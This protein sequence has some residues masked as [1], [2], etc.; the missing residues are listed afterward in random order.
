MPHVI[1]VDP[2]SRTAFVDLTG[3]VDGAEVIATCRELLTHPDWE[4][5]FSALWD[6]SELHELHLLPEHI[7]GFMAE[8]SGFRRRRGEGRTAV[9]AGGVNARLSALLFSIQA[10]ANSYRLFRVFG[11]ADEGEAWLA[12]GEGVHVGE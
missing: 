11:D 6:A 7:I 5:G 4:R 8:A 9:V 12:G 10:G 3:T 1:L 2:S